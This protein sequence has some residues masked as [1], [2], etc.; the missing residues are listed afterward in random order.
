MRRLGTGGWLRPRLPQTVRVRLSVSYAVLFLAAGATLLGLTYGLV[1]SSLPSAAPTKIS[2]AQ[3][4]KLEAACKHAGGP[5]AKTS[6]GKPQ[7]AQGKPQIQPVPTPESCRQAFAAGS[8]AATSSQRDQTLHDL[9]LFSLLGL[10]L[11]SLVSGGLGWVMAGRVLRPVR[12]ITGAARRASVRRRR[13]S[14]WR[15]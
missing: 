1:A 8:R 2:K 12:T 10:G 3:E 6:G 11:M 4:A 5:V 15:G 14:G 9:L 7:V 13:P